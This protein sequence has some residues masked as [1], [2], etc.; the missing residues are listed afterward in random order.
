MTGLDVG[1]RLIAAAGRDAVPLLLHRPASVA[2]RAPLLVCVHGYTRQPLDHLQAFAPL[3]AEAGFALLL[4]LFRDS[5]P[6]RMY[7]QLVHPRRG[8][9][10]DLALLQAIEGAAD[11]HGLDA[12]RIHLFGYSGG[13]QFV[14]RLALL[15]PQRVASLGLGAAGWYTWPDLERTWPQGLAGAPDSACGSVDLDAFLRL[16]I[17]LWVGERDDASDTHLR[18]DPALNSLQGPNRL[19]R[20][21]RWAAAVREQGA[22]RG[23]EARV[24]LDVLPLAGHDFLACHR[25]AGLAMRALAHAGQALRGREACPTA[26]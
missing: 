19:E 1:L 24:S 12:T 16:P 4:P 22:R 3:A 14:H 25:K 17:A 7:Q 13:A 8:T 15:H 18:E 9:R 5:G 10:S 2:A 11:E 21:R 23:V 6:H 26:R 20:A